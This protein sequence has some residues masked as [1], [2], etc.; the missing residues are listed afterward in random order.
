MLPLYLIYISFLSW[1]WLPASGLWWLAMTLTGWLFIAYFIRT[2]VIII[3]DREY[4]MR[5]SVP[6]NLR[7]SNR[8]EEHSSIYDICNRD[9]ACYRNSILLFRTKCFLRILAWGF[10]NC[11]LDR[12]IYQA[13]PAIGDPGLGIWILEP[14]CYFCDYYSCFI[15]CQD[16]TWGMRLIQNAY[17]MHVEYYV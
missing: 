2:Q 14:G 8:D 16:R 4:N 6:W 11:R 1:F 10:R 9:A 7:R 3:R 15:C 17:V 12:L 5:I 13:E